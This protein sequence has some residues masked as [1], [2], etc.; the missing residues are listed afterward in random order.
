MIN[1]ANSNINSSDAFIIKPV[2]TVG[3]QIITIID[4][5]IVER[6]K[7]DE[8][9]LLQQQ[10]TDEGYILLKPIKLEILK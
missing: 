9:T 7:F 3:T 10:V 1:S 8:K 2:I 4:K 6:L 5:K